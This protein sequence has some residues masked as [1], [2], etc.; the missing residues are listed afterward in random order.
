M[1]ALNISDENIEAAQHLVR[2]ASEEENW[3]RYPD[4]NWTPGDRPEYC[5]HFDTYRC[6]FTYTKQPN[7]PLIR[8]LSVS[9]PSHLQPNKVAVCTI[10]SWFGFTG[11]E[12]K[13]GIVSEPGKNWLMAPGEA[14]GEKCIIVAQKV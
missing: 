4:S 1:R 6:V 12:E 9:V 8:H 14:P 10:A 13:A 3:Y 5:L 7:Q 2:F 11:A